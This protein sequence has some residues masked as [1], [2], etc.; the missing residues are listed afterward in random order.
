MIIA[1]IVVGSILTYLLSAR[2]VFGIMSAHEWPKFRY[3]DCSH[4]FH[5]IHK[6]LPCH[7]SDESISKIVRRIM[8]LLAPVILPP[9]ALVV[10]IQLFVFKGQMTPTERERTV[11]DRERAVKQAE[12]DAELARLEMDV[13]TKRRVI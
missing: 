6:N 5:N 12:D 11:A 4:G 3:Y 9:I 7:E 8:A 13:A 10:F 1:I 2:K